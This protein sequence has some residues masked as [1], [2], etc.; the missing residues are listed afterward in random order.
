MAELT[1]VES[2]N[3]ALH[4]A[5]AADESVLVLGQDVGVDGGVFRVTDGLL[6]RFGENRSVDTPLAESVIVGAAVGMAVAGLRPV[7][8]MQFSGFS[9]YG[10]AQMEG[11]A[12]RLRWRTRGALTVPMVL[13]MPY[14]AGVRALEHHS[15]S[16][17]VYYAHTPGLK[18]VMPSG[19]RM[20][21]ALLRTAIDDPD[22]VVFMEPKLLYR[23]VREEVPEEP[24]RMP[25]G[26]ARLARRGEDLTLVA[27]GAMLPRT[28][29]AAE[30]LDEEDGVGCDVIDLVSVAP[31]DAGRVVSSVRKTRRALVVHEAPRTYGPA[32]E[33]VARLNEQAFYRLEAPVQRVTG[34]DVPVPYFAREN[35]YLPGVDRI[36]DAARRVLETEA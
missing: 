34:Y 30:T 33:L 18:V 19:P 1:M 2:I 24:E 25:I 17:E 5:M 26:E 15:E 11:H 32:A 28:L 23:S 35:E 31:L 21:R 6:D 16:R 27:H 20:A 9:Y 3:L 22:P 4:E 13:R 7:A 29:E 12:A 36:V 10:F 8:E 14:G